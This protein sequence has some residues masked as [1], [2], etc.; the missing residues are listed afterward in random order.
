VLPASYRTDRTPAGAADAA[1]AGG[2]ATA[3]Q[4][5]GGVSVPLIAGLVVV[6]VAVGIL[7]SQC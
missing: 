3:D 7:L 2:S 1:G 4:P 5:K 6:V